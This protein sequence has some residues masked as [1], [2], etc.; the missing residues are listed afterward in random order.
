[1]NDKQFNDICKKLDRIF[2]I[3]AVQNI[4]NK[5]DKIFTLKHLGF[6]FKEIGPLIGMKD[7][8]KTEGWNR[9]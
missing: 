7:V 6:G 4:D 1:M 9:K 5:D 3:I 8:R 2:A